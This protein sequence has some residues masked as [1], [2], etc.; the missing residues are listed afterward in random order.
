MKTVFLLL[1]LASSTA[2]AKDSLP[3]VLVFGKTMRSAHE[4]II[5][6]AGKALVVLAKKNGFDA[7]FSDDPAI[8]SEK[9]LAGFTAVIFLDVS[10][11]VLDTAQ[12]L[13]FEKF[14]EQGGGLVAIHASI[15]AGKDW[16]WY[17]DLIGTLF[18]DHPKIQTATIH[19]EKT[20]APAMTN[21]P[22][23]WTQS[24]EWYN[25]TNAIPAGYPVLATVDEATYHGGKMGKSH[26]V[27][28][29]KEMGKA[30][31]WYTAMGHDSSLYQDQQSP[32]DQQIVWALKWAS[33]VKD[34]KEIN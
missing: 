26:P 8:F 4:K 15:S 30:R 18:Q 14:F 12:K 22:D 24:D 17:R 11:G 19:I 28:W 5:P 21:L 33:H 34:G 3:K 1:W 23:S 10:Q 2:Y 29:C 13:A 9:K 25:Y 27:T 6:V 20:A 32:F 31:V 7:T 16:P